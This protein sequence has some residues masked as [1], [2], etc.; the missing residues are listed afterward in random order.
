MSTW[1]LLG[2]SHTF[3]QSGF[4]ICEALA[5]ARPGVRVLNG[6]VNADLAWNLSER[7]EDALREA[8]ALIHVL[9]G[10]N[11]VNAGLHP[12]HAAGYIRDKGIP[13][14]PTPD[15]YR[16]QLRKVFARLNQTG[17]T[18][19]VS[20]IPPIGDDSGSAWNVSV[21]HHNRILAEEAHHANVRVIPLYEKLMASVDEG[22]VRA[23]DRTDWGMWIPESQ[24]LHDEDGWGWDAIADRRG[25][26]LTHDGLHLTDRAGRIWLNLLLE[27]FDGAGGHVVHGTDHF[28]RS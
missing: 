21:R 23:I 14:V 16:S 24:R 7:I 17:S 13:T 6:G 15:F 10:T 9:I 28:Q 4:A 2:D 1:L 22:R 3:G 11:D 8:P 25:L 5:A 26:Q 19:F 27:E 18:L 20:T 12:D